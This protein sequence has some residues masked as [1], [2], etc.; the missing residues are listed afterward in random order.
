[1][2]NGTF[3]VAFSWA[4]ILIE[5][6]EYYFL[7]AASKHCFFLDELEIKS[8]MLPLI[9]NSSFVPQAFSTF[10]DVKSLYILPRLFSHLSFAICCSM[11]SICQ[12]EFL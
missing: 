2:K 3:K 9:I 12:D 1:M 6:T 5:Q 8:G 10:L 7:P 4:V 11:L